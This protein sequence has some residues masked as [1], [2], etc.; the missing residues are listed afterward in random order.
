MRARGTGEHGRRLWDPRRVDAA[1]AAG[2]PIEPRRAAPA[3]ERQA[4]ALRHAT[5]AAA[6][7]VAVVVTVVGIVVVPAAAAA[8]KLSG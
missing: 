8:T 3:P 5:P 1:V 2:Q 7:G 4:A 6:A